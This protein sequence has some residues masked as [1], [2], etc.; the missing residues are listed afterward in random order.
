M[1]LQQVRDIGE[2]MAEC[3]LSVDR[4]AQEYPGPTETE[5]DLGVGFE[6][7]LKEG[8][9][10]SCTG[11]PHV[12]IERRVWS[13]QD[14]HCLIQ[15]GLLNK[16][17]MRLLRWALADAENR[18]WIAVSLYSSILS[19]AVTPQQD[20]AE[21]FDVIVEGDMALLREF[22]KVGLTGV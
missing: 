1:G 9:K 19:S 3:L 14:V 21:K 16:E 8:T 13:N 18:R 17:S 7:L 6:R 2:P 15:T 11:L 10:D 22:G 20:N 12:L 5:M 4:G